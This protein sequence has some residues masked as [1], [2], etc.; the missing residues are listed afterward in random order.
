MRLTGSTEANSSR[1][2]ATQ[3][4]FARVAPLLGT[5]LLLGVFG[6]FLMATVLTV[7]RAL[8]VRTGLWWIALAQAHGHLQ[9]YGW[10]GLF[11]LGV[12]FHFLPR[13]RGSPLAYPAAARWI[14]L[15]LTL[16]L[17]A[18]AVAQPLL[19]GSGG[20][21]GA[22]SGV[23]RLLLVASGVLELLA[24]CGAVALLLATARNGP[25]MATRPALWSVLPFLAGVCAAL[26]LAALSNLVN[27]WRAAS[28]STGLVPGAGDS[29]NITLGL[30]GFLVPM[31]LA[32]SA[33]AMPM[34]AGLT[35]FPARWLWPLAFAYFSGLALAC[36]GAGQGGLSATWA[37]ALYGV[38]L[39]V[40]GA[41]V[42]LFVGVF[43][44]LMRT[45]GRLPERVRSL[46]PAPAASERAYQTK[47]T[48]EKGAYGP[49]VAII[50]SAYMWAAFGGLLLLIDGV[51]LAIGSYAPFAV[52]AARHS[53]AVGFIALLICGIAPRML[54][55]FSGGR[56][57]SP[58]LVRATLWLGNGAALLRVGAVLLA[59][60]LASLGDAGATLDSVIFGLS[61][62]FGLAL[63][64]CLAVN[65]WPALQGGASPQVGSQRA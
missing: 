14:L 40:M 56:I 62:P 36:I 6:G 48:Q 55:G 3:A 63:A 60:P 2:P 30:F 17:I 19:A 11:V 54:P 12:A 45:R 33:R 38:G 13:L 4:P 61:G 43:V 16:G 21:S 5:A 23:W 39:A 26:T 57:V 53:F 42:I 27:V 7:T 35:A 52:D 50:A 1:A 34:Y 9:L 41:V 8:D 59:Q 25:R 51:S 20:A 47:V 31:A 15:A 10:A 29:V 32:M 18:R 46:S 64:I 65:L 24:L 28:S 58:A 37:N 22:G 44:R 49:F